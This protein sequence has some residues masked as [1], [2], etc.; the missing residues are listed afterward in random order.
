MKRWTL[1][2]IAFMLYSSEA[3]GQV[4]IG[5]R[6]CNNKWDNQWIISA[7]PEITFSTKWFYLSMDGTYGYFHPSDEPQ[8]T[9]FQA[10]ASMVP[11]F[12]ATM[13]PLFLAAGYG[14]GHHFRRE[15]RVY[16]NG[17][18]EIIEK[19]TI[20]GEAR[21]LLGLQIKITNHLSGIIKGGYNYIN[22]EH[23][24]YSGSMGIEFHFGSHSKHQTRPEIS[25]S[26]SG[27]LGETN[28][29]RSFNFI[30]LKSEDPVVTEINKSIEGIL[31][32]KH[33]DIYN[34]SNLQQKVL[35]TDTTDDAERT[36]HLMPAI[37]LATKGAS[38]LNIDYIIDTQVRYGYKTYGGEIFV[39]FAS[40]RIIKAQD[41]LVAWSVNLDG[42]NRKLKTVKDILN[43]TIKNQIQKLQY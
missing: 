38:L 6:L 16:E 43:E 19:N 22:E 42:S 18:T 13:G 11:M 26:A 15:D 17:T 36:V 27:N 23:S 29:K 1:P 2:L 10:R 28:N 33:H 12:K 5:L 25:S 30:F 7:A 8:N 37:E 40:L 41:G 21:L 20:A 14:I 34:W 31:I 35:E 24:Y 9:I 3:I 4:G 39:Q 32:E